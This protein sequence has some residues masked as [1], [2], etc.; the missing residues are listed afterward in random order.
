[1]LGQPKGERVEVDDP[2]NWEVEAG[3]SENEFMS[4]VLRVD[5][6]LDLNAML[7]TQRPQI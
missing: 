7:E 5:L 2:Q 1:M 4:L 3:Q 6:D